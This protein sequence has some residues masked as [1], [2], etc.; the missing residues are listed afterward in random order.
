MAFRKSYARDEKPRW[1]EVLLSD[2]EELAQEA[3]ARDD[4]MRLM[5]ECINDAQELFS[6]EELKRYQT[7]I[8]RVAIALFEKRASH[9]VFYKEEKARE[10][11]QTEML[12][13]AA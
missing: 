13:A 10:K 3:L 6:A 11:F 12:K 1:Q 4:N 7:D 9:V 2:K 5:Q 8:V